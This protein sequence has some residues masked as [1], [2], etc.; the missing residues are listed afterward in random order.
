[1]PMADPRPG[2]APAH[3][4]AAGARADRP[5]LVVRSRGSAC[6]VACGLL[7]AALSATLPI[8]TAARD[9]AASAIVDPRVNAPGRTSLTATD[10]PRARLQ[11]SRGTAPQRTPWPRPAHATSGVRCAGGLGVGAGAR[12]VPVVQG[13]HRSSRADLGPGSRF[14]RQTSGDGT[15]ALLFAAAALV[16]GLWCRAAVWVGHAFLNS[17]RSCPRHAPS[18]P[19]P[20]PVVAAGR[21]P[22]AGQRRAPQRPPCAAPE[23]RGRW[24][25]LM[26]GADP[27][28]RA[29]A[30]VGRRLRLPR[31]RAVRGGGTSPAHDGAAA[32]VGP[33]RRGP[34]A[35]LAVRVTFLQ[36]SEGSSRGTVRGL[37]AQRAPDATRLAIGTSGGQVHL[38]CA[39]DGAQADGWRLD[40]TLQHGGPVFAVLAAGDVLVSGGMDCVATVW[41]G[42]GPSDGPSPGPSDGAEVEALAR[43]PGHTGWTRA[44]AVTAEYVFSVGCN[45]VKVWDRRTLTHVCDLSITNS[46]AAFTR[47]GDILCLT[48]AEAYLF[49]GGVDGRCHRWHIPSAVQA[50]R[51]EGVGAARSADDYE[52]AALARPT[53][54]WGD[55]VCAHRGRVTA[56]VHDAAAVEERAAS[57]P[58]PDVT[59]AP[60][61]DPRAGADADRDSEVRPSRKQDPGCRPSRSEGGT[62]S[63]ARPNTHPFVYSASVD[64]TVQAW[65]LETASWSPGPAFVYNP[66]SGDPDLG[67]ATNPSPL[68][69]LAVLPDIGLL[70]AGTGDGDVVL[71]Q[72]PSL[73]VVAVVRDVFAELDTACESRTA[74]APKPS[75]ITCLTAL[76]DGRLAVGSTTRAHVAVLS[77]GQGY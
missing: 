4:I 9:T 37:A 31:A 20:A 60:T 1:M 29:R 59:V 65:P 51:A 38:W 6:A 35:G 66:Q 75:P 23:R 43:L 33:Q 32:E 52:W 22:N 30:D 50:V 67:G 12:A 45:Y 26:M 7:A 39:R 53:P 62:T 17:R 42:A 47:S 74:G 68:S 76:P 46:A 14:A 15:P 2:P 16:G 21:A 18:M 5:G 48:A 41:G 49:A 56:V 11:R 10:T 13:D 71:L 69:S 70:A 19:F 28:L 54:A 57:R 3:S 34:G 24:A 40:Q 58:E 61:P 63:G 73:Q 77:F 25:M 72:R 36:M 44:L 55:A 64:G 27:P 8:L